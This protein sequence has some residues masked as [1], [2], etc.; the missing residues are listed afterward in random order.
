VK[1]ISIELGRNP[2]FCKFFATLIFLKFSFIRC[3]H[4]AVRLK[5][6]WCTARVRVHFWT[7]YNDSSE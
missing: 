1:P 4:A 6:R 3:R 5:R 7:V 2:L